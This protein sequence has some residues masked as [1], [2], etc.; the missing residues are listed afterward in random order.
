VDAEEVPSSESSGS[1]SSADAES[2][3]FSSSDD[4]E[5]LLGGVAA[6]VGRSVR[7]G[8][9]SALFFD[10]D[11]L[12]DDKG[13]LRGRGL[14]DRLRGLGDW[15]RGRGLGDRRRGLGGRLRGRG[16]GDR[17]WGRRRR[18]GGLGG[19][20]DG[21]RS[22]RRLYFFLAAAFLAVFFLAVFFLAVF[23]LSVAFLGFFLAGAALLVCAP[24][25]AAALLVFAA[26]A[27]LLFF[28]A[29]AGRHLKKEQ[30]TQ[31]AEANREH[32]RKQRL[33]AGQV[34]FSILFLSFSVKI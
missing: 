11:G 22:T 20:V 27:A 28:G 17:L 13:T 8:S 9:G 19:V 1:L 21:L 32:Q 23:F 2:L 12:G 4:S 10:D 30:G 7:L 16:L 34:A 5:L 3:S 18:R 14:G 15:L 29:T 6:A 25:A 33:P 26:A 24:G 31:N